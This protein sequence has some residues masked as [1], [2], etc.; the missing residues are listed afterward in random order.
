MFTA[1]VFRSFIFTSF[2]KYP[3]L[4]YF[5]SMIFLTFIL[6]RF[7]NLSFLGHFCLLPLHLT[8]FYIVFKQTSFSSPLFT[9]SYF[10]ISF[11][12]TILKIPFS[13][14]SFPVATILISGTENICK[15]SIALFNNRDKECS[16]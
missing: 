9:D 10:R 2:F 6:S 16:K 15:L 13:F 12:S 1:R 3:T 11:L 7:A 5:L 8:H 4:L 14:L